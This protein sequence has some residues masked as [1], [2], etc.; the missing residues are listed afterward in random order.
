MMKRITPACLPVMVLLCEILFYAA[1]ATHP[2]VAVAPPPAPPSALPAPADAAAT[3]R[4]PGRVGPASLYPDSTL[5][6]GK[7]DTVSLADLTR[8]YPCPSSIHKSDCTYSQS[9]RSVSASEHKLIYDAYHVPANRR[10][11]KSGEIDH[12]DPL[13][14][15]GSND[16]ENLWFQPIHAMWN[17]KDFGFPVKDRLEAFICAEVQAK[18]M[19]PKVAYDRMTS[20]WVQFYLEN[21]SKLPRKSGGVE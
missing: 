7:F 21:E 13:C 10:N 20:D 18:R 3:R 8:R 5:T 11:I 2:P 16:K 19:D 1:C 15:G 9:H 4:A 12:V 17:G 14:N 6:P